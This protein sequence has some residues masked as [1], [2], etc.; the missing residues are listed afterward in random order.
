MAL[1][2]DIALFQR[3]HTRRCSSFYNFLEFLKQSF[4]DYEQVT[5]FL[6]RT[7]PLLTLH[8][9]FEV[10]DNYFWRWRQ[11]RFAS[12]DLSF[13][14]AVLFFVVLLAKQFDRFGELVLSVDQEPTFAS[15]LNKFVFP[16]DCVDVEVQTHKL[17]KWLLSD[18]ALGLKVHLLD[19]LA[20]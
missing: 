3:I 18:Y 8:D 5:Q 11:L 16:S 15:S 1:L 9:A 10:V 20:G 17:G 6:I 12:S 13:C 7:H 14:K 2:V 4:F 19:S